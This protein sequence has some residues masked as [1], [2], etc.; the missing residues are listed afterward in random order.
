MQQLLDK[1][2]AQ[3]DIFEKHK[4]L[5]GENFNIFSIMTMENDEVFT[6]SALI[7]ELLNPKGSHSLGKIPLELFIKK[8]IVGKLDINFD[9]IKSSKEVSIGKINKDKTEGG[10]L[11]IVVEN[12]ISPIFAIENKIYAFEQ[13]NQLLRYKNEYPDA[14]LFYL[15]LDG[16]QSK[17]NIVNKDNEVY[18]AI[19]YENHILDWVEECVKYAYDK[20]MVREVL[21]Q[22]IYLIKKLTN[23]TTNKKMS[24]KIIK[25]IKKNLK[26][27]E[28]I[29]NNFEDAVE[30]IRKKFLKDLKKKFVNNVEGW[31]IEIK[32]DEEK[33]VFG[34]N[35]IKEHSNHHLIF[36]FNNYN[37]AALNLINYLDETQLADNKEINITDF[38]F[39]KHSLSSKSIYYIIDKKITPHVLLGTERNAKL[40]KYFAEILV[41]LEEIS[42]NK[43]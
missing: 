9:D 42:K 21:N 13:E 25:L 29:H 24:E 2:K 10:R 38:A 32:K 20:P 12:S 30:Q 26:A 35:I 8:H 36:R 4:E 34:L 37:E 15:T 41:V 23:Q 17:Q 39:K 16:S 6:H 3:I 22:Y 14:D 1:V 27:S 33:K 31:I 28:E 43:M 11:D 40:D 5:S 7:A 18:T 19:S